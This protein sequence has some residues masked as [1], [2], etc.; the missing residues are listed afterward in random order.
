MSGLDERVPLI[1]NFRCWSFLTLSPFLVPRKL[2]SY[3]V[4]KQPVF[5]LRDILS[6][7]RNSG[8]AHGKR[9]KWDLL[10]GSILF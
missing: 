2:K 8:D 10:H 7:L 3:L 5:K 9:C 1:Q 4:C 6:S